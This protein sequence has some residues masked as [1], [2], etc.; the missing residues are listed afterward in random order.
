[1]TNIF[2]R[3]LDLMNSP[4]QDSLNMSMNDCHQKGLFSLV[5]GGTEHCKLTRIFVAK[6]KIKPFSAQLHSHV[7]DLNIGVIKGSFL[8]H[9]AIEFGEGAKGVNICYLKKYNYQ[10]PLNGGI[11]LKYISE[12]PYS[13]YDYYVPESGMIHLQHDVI[14]TVSVSKG[15]MWIVEE[16]GMKSESSVV[17][18]KKF[19]LD[20]LYNQPKQYQ[21]NDIF[22]I[23]K[24]ELEIICAK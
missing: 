6:N 1:M 16:L 10:S 15:T 11:G 18:G 4:D 22:Q 21:I 14:H 2:E 7:Y 19:I 5:V 8:N 23:V 12:M 24:K 13:L 20:G 17:V 9:S 3:T